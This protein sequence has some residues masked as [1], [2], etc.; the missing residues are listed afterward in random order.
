M[1]KSTQIAG[2]LSKLLILKDR[3]NEL[4]KQEGALERQYESILA[5]VYANHAKRIP[6]LTEVELIPPMFIQGSKVLRVFLN[7]IEVLEA[8]VIPIGECL[9]LESDKN[10]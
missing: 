3:L 1:T 6:H 4:Y 2:Q 7:R 10:D 9:R 5:K 8:E